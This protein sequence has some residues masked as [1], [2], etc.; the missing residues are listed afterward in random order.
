MVKS[1]DP[2]ER[3]CCSKLLCC[4]G[5]PRRA[6][7]QIVGEEKRETKTTTCGSVCCSRCCRVFV[8]LF[9]IVF[10]ILGVKFPSKFDPFVVFAHHVGYTGQVL[11]VEI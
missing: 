1:K 4:G 8:F 2:N 7:Y 9:A 11:Q 3:R 5:N 10:V 6:G